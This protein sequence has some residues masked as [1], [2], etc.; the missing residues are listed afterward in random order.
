[1]EGTARGG[2]A[3]AKPHPLSI[4]AGRY[5]SAVDRVDQRSNGIRGEPGPEAFRILPGKGDRWIRS[6]NECEKVIR[7]VERNP[8]K[9]GYVNP[10]KT[11]NGRVP[12]NA[13]KVACP[14]ISCFAVT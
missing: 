2:C 11:G 12:V 7:Y 10:L 6:R 14:V 5:P 13:T 4:E 8:V 3:H 1:M 9:A